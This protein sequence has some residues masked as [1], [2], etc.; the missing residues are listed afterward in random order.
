MVRFEQ[1]VEQ[2]R[3]DNQKIMAGLSQ[4]QYTFSELWEKIEENTQLKTFM[5][6]RERKC[7]C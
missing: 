5:V 1:I 7:K 4:S 6:L 2:S 3:Q